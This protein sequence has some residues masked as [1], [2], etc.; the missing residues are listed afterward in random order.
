MVLVFQVPCFLSAF[1]IKMGMWVVSV[2]NVS[3]HG[4]KLMCLSMS[5]FPSGLR[6]GLETVPIG[7][8]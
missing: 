3:D 8:I 5:D 4:V 7:I 2:L 6:Q 1:F